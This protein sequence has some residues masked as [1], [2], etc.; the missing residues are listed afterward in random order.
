[1]INLEEIRKQL[2]D[3]RLRVVSKEAGISYPTLLAIRDGENKNPQYNT[4][5]KI[6]AYLEGK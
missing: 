1:M 4:M 5:R 2:S 6:I 3:R